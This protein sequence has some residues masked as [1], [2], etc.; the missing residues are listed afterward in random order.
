[1]KTQNP[2]SEESNLGID[3]HLELTIYNRTTASN[4]IAHDKEYDNAD[5][6]PSRYEDS[7][8]QASKTKGRPLTP[9]KEYELINAYCNEIGK[10]HLFTQKEEIEVSAQIKICEEKIK[11]LTST[12]ERLS[13]KGPTKRLI[14]LSYLIMLYSQKAKQLKE[15]FI[16]ANL[17]LVFAMAN[18]YKSHRHQLL[19]LIQEGNIGL[20]KAV[21]RFD[22]KRGNRFS[23]YAS[24]WIHQALIRAVYEQTR[25]IKIPVYILEQKNK[26]YRTIST[27]QRERG[28]TPLSEE[29]A[30]RARTA[31]EVVNLILDG[32]DT[33]VFHLDSPLANDDTTTMLDIV[34]DDSM[35]APDHFTTNTELIDR[36]DESMSKL[37]DRE[38]RIISSR[39]GIGQQIPH[40]LDEIGKVFNVTRERIRQI[41]KGAFKKLANSESGTILRSFL[42]Q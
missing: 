14:T 32:I 3:E 10:Q 1:M 36:L 30:E 8:S 26:I 39:F 20:I 6:F 22:Y 12:V 28:R 29:I 31:V 15:R 18:K 27:I 23:T 25:T 35:P 40:T 42:Y 38:R 13:K 4:E 5:E 21:E 19:D 41:E 37:S 17:K 9:E 33:K 7:K 2:F 16:K 34:Q 11:Q 24:W